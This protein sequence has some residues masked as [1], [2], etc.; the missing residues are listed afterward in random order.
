[1]CPFPQAGSVIAEV[2]R[3]VRYASRVRSLGHDS[4][5]ENLVIYSRLVNQLK[6][7]KEIFIDKSDCKGSS[8]STIDSTSH[9]TM[10]S[11]EQQT[12][13][14]TLEGKYC[15]VASLHKADNTIEFLAV[16]ALA[17]N[18]ADSYDAKAH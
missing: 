9:T 18:W 1:M 12:K 15:A 6:N 7:Y 3:G 2:R 5:R 16:S 11:I 17:F 8:S 14:L 4:D 10:G 13:S